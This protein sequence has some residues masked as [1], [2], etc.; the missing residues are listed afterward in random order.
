MAAAINNKATAANQPF[1]L[2]IQHIVNNFYNLFDP[3]DNMLQFSYKF[4]EKQDPLGLL[5]LQVGQPRPSKYTEHNV[6]FEL[7]PYRN[8]NGTAQPDC[9]DFSVVIWG[10]NHCGY[11]GFRQAKPF[12]NLL[13]DDGAINVVV[14]DWMATASPRIR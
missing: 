13:R 8:A 7:P 5:G 11:M 1:G 4:T 2:A 14:G 12:D 3:E 10:D 6:L 9:L